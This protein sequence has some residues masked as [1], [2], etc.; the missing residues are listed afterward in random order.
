MDE[1]HEVRAEDSVSRAQISPSER[2]ASRITKKGKDRKQLSDT[3][4]NA[5]L[6][7][8]ENVSPG[9]EDTQ[10]GKDRRPSGIVIDGKTYTCAACK[11]GHRV[12]VC[13]HARERPMTATHPPG[14]PPAGAPKKVICNCPK[15][16]NCRKR[17]CKCARKCSCTQIM[18]MLVYIPAPGAEGATHEEQGS[19]QKGQQ[20]VTDLKGNILTP[21]Q[22]KERQQQKETQKVQNNDLI[23]PSTRTKIPTEPTQTS[24]PEHEAKPEE[25]GGCCTHKEKVA[26]KNI[27]TEASSQQP[28]NS[29]NATSGC[30]CGGTCTCAFCPEHPNNSTSTNMAREQAMYFAN[31][32]YNND[33]Q[34]I[35]SFTPTVP[36]G[37]SCMGG[38]PRFAVS[39]YPERPSYEDL[40]TTFPNPGYVIG[41]PFWSTRTDD[42]GF[43]IPPFPMHSPMNLTVDG[44]NSGGLHEM[45][46]PLHTPHTD[47]PPPEFSQDEFGIG[48]AFVAS[49]GTGDW[50]QDFIPPSMWTMDGSVPMPLAND[51]SNALDFPSQRA[52][53][54]PHPVT[55]IEDGGL[56]G[57]TDFQHDGSGHPLL[58]MNLPTTLP[59]N[60]HTDQQLESQ[61]SCCNNSQGPSPTSQYTHLPASYLSHVPKEEPHPRSHA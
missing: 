35:V 31:R 42:A 57:F 52:P 25:A 9:S 59:P 21:E 43:S 58:D 15:Q 40:Q 14:R 50:G 30:N 27:A 10:D 5:V 36:Q 3:N 24:L 20:V 13:K 39:R 26:A 46:A 54:H 37:A 56:Y 41:Y 18:Y 60:V 34:P 28:Q 44:I 51:F 16:C 12:G 29:Q 23:T 33:Q 22:V 6:E 55:P 49:A 38:L 4:I 17:D 2:R 47:M 32:P 45:P 8:A 1:T 53:M 61:G 19:W 48:N 7:A 11:A